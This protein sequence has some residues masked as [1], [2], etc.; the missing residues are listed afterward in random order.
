MLQFLSA[1]APFA[2][3]LQT[4]IWVSLVVALMLWFNK[5][6][7]Q[8]LAAVQRRIESGSTVK[9]GWFELSQQLKPEPP[10][11]Q[12]QRA[13][14][15]LED[16]TLAQPPEPLPHGA[17]A[18]LDPSS[19]YLLV[20]DLALR[21]LQADLGVPLNRQISAGPDAGFDA[22][23]ARDGK[24]NIV[25]VKY[26]QGAVTPD[27][28]RTALERIAVA[29]QRVH[30]KNVRIILVLV[31]KRAENVSANEE[32]VQEAI[33]NAPLP[34]DVRTYTLPELRNRVGIPA[35]DA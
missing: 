3:V 25:E 27:K 21:A 8:I 13:R 7:R 24:L 11:E 19:Q 31:Y 9:A 15:E 35:S 34:V 16:A 20:E 26:F 22:A 4:L 12:R 2:P 14:I 5:P 18:P 29:V 10:E 23:F 17:V 28:L 1:L 30:W 6:I 32:R 33:A